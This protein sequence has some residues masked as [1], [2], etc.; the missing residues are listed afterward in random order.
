[1]RLMDDVYL[2]HQQHRQILHTIMD[3]MLESITIQTIVV[4][5]HML[6]LLRIRT[7]QSVHL[8]RVMHCILYPN[9]II[10]L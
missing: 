8:E 10:D 4:A 9:C 6:Y 3:M 5:I 7:G 1:M 2:V